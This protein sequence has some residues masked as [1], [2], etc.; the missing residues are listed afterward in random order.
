MKTLQIE[1]AENLSLNGVVTSITIEGDTL[2]IESNEPISW[3][4]AESV[5]KHLIKK[6]HKQIVKIVYKELITC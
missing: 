6:G 2:R 1:L 3:S 5:A 4:S